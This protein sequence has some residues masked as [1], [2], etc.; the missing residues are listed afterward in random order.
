MDG[1]SAV[2]TEPRI[3]T[4]SV[5]DAFSIAHKATNAATDAPRMGTTASA[6]GALDFA[7]IEAGTIPMMAGFPAVPW[8]SRRNGFP[9]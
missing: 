1:L 5:P 3:T 9:C 4:P 6:N 8:H 2:A 7:S